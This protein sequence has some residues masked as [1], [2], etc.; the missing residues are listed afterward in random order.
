M[1]LPGVID[2][3]LAE[4]E[5]ALPFRG[6]AAERILSEV[7]DHLLDTASSV[8][9][10]GLSLDDAAAEAVIRFGAAD[11]VAARFAAE[12]RAPRF[13]S[14]MCTAV[15]LLFAAL[16]TVLWLIYPDPGIE[17][18]VPL[19]LGAAA[20]AISARRYVPD[21]VGWF[22]RTS[23]PLGWKAARPAGTIML[24]LAASTLVGLAAYESYLASL[25]PRFV[26]SS[27]AYA[28]A[29]YALLVGSLL[30]HIVHATAGPLDARR[31]A[32]K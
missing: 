1:E 24:V 9:R 8:R 21:G 18:T 12:L 26:I 29:F 22:V 15:G 7:G 23:G 14:V 31:P 10:E 25:R 5:R 28:V 20:I 19:A 2:G 3:Y 16:G 4:L 6:A 30:V 32:A 11:A 27:V 17:M 13:A